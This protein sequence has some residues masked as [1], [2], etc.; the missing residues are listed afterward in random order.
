MAHQQWRLKIS[1]M[2][3]NWRQRRNGGVSTIGGSWRWRKRKA[4]GI[5]ESVKALQLAYTQRWL[6][7]ETAQAIGGGS[8]L[9]GV[10][11]KLGGSEEAL[12]ASGEKLGSA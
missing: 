9:A 3:R 10:S 2:R 6:S 7:A 12:A 5:A 8:G 11:R 4:A 1:V